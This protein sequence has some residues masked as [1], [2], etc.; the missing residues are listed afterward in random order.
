MAAVVVWRKS[1]SCAF[2]LLNFWYRV[3]TGWVRNLGRGREEE[4]DR[5]WVWLWGRTRLLL[6][7]DMVMMVGDV[8]QRRGLRDV[9]KIIL[10]GSW[11]I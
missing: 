6:D 4:E 1:V 11:V 2:M 9:G 5:D 8:G 3:G 7:V 10:G